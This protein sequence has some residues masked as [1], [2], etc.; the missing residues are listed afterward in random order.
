MLPT[1]IIP[2]LLSAVVLA[3]DDHQGR[4]HDDLAERLNNVDLSR[5]KDTFLGSMFTWYGT[6]TGADACTGKNHKDSDWYVAM[7][8][9]QFGDGSGCCGR[10]LKLNYNGKTAVATCVD[11]CPTCPEWAHLDLTKGLFQ[12]FNNGDLGTGTLYG[13]WSYVD[14]HTEDGPPPPPS[15]PKQ[16][17]VSRKPDPTSSSKKVSSSAHQSSAKVSS[18]EKHSSSKFPSSSHS[19]STSPS[20]SPSDDGIAN[21]GGAA[22]G[23]PNSPGAGSNTTG[24]SGAI[25]GTSGAVSLASRNLGVVLAALALVVVDTIFTSIL[26]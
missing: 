19:T 14:G 23:D 18:S 26:G 3:R 16:S 11:E 4:A 21:V 25:K 20:A 17:R 6:N 10:Q 5:R 24:I 7:N 12:Y 15:P 9:A 22:A 1:T 2:L 13:S 8:T